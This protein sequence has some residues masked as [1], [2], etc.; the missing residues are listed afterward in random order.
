MIGYNTLQKSM[1]GVKVLTDGVSF[2]S[3]G[4]AEH[5]NIVYSEFIKS[6]T[7]HTTLSDNS[8]T[9]DDVNCVNI[10]CD[11]FD[12]S[13]IQTGTIQANYLKILNQL[14]SAI[15]L[16]VDGITQNKIIAN[17]QMTMNNILQLVNADIQ[18]TQTGR[19]YQQGTNNNYLKDTYINGYLQ[20]GSNITQSGGSAS[21]NDLT[22]DNLTMRTDKGIIQ[23]GTNVTNSFGGTSTMKTLIVTDSVTLPSNVSIPNVTTSNDMMM[24]SDAVIIQDITTVTTK[25]NILRNTKT[26]TF[27]ADGDI[28]QIKAGSTATFKNTIIQGTS[29]MQGDITQTAGTC[30]FKTINCN[31]ITLN[32]DQLITQSGTGYIT[33]SGTGQ[34]VLK[35]IN[36]LNNANIIFNG[37]GIISQALNGINILSHFRSAGYGIIGGRNNTTFTNTQ[38]IQ[39]NNGLQIQFN[40]DNSSQYSF[41]MNNRGTGGNGGIR[42]QRYVTGVY[43]DEPMVI[44]DNI[45]MNKNLSIPGGSLTCSSA[46]IGNI[47]QSELDCLDNC[48]QN[49]NTKFTSLDAQI[50]ALQTSS[51]N[52]NTALT[53]ITYNST[54]DLTTIDNNLTISA[55]KNLTVGTTN[56]INAINSINSTLSGISY[57]STQDIT[58]INNHLLLPSGNNFFLGSGYNVKTNI[59]DCLNKLSGVTYASGTDT[60]T[61]DNNLTV[62]KTLIVQGMNIKAEIDALDTSFTTGTIN[63][64]NLVTGNLTATGTTNLKTTNVIT[65]NGAT[66]TPSL[67]VRDNGNATFTRTL[68]IIPNSSGGAYNSNV[69]SNDLS[70]VGTGTSSNQTTLS[71]CTWSSTKSGFRTGPQFCELTAGTNSIF[72]DSTTGTVINGSTTFN[73]DVYNSNTLNI[74]KM[75]TDPTYSFSKTLGTSNVLVSTIT[76]QSNY[77]QRIFVNTPVSVYRNGTNNSGGNQTQHFETLSSISAYYT[78]N[79]VFVGNLTVTTNNTL[80]ATKQM[81]HINPSFIY[82]QYYT[83]ASC[84]FLPSL[85]TVSGV[86]KIYFTFT[87]S[88]TVN[89]ADNPGTINGY[90]V[91]TSV[92]S[93]QAGSANLFFISS[94]GLNYSSTSFTTSPF[95]VNY[96]NSNNNNS[97]LQINNLVSNNISNQSIIKTNTINSVNSNFDNSNISSLNVSSV[98]SN[99]NFYGNLRSKSFIAGY[100]VDGSKPYSLSP[101]FCSLS[102]ISPN[103]ADDYY[104][105]FPGYRFELYDAQDYGGTKTTLTNTSVDNLP[106]IKTVPLTNTTS[107]IKVYYRPTNNDNFVEITMPNIS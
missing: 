22:I 101:V 103:N 18:Q 39:N 105:I 74:Y 49:I 67:I 12:A 30:I 50:L 26:L 89:F 64:N 7:G 95:D 88:Y 5:Q 10:T 77:N 48:N 83:N 86:Y 42:F 53:G 100:L 44:D 81:N 45:T 24:Q 54:G 70:I 104:I 58:T 75:T 43:L 21:L 4:N 9:T 1:N 96:M 35:E 69:V 31:N 17:V 16:E 46:T 55:G 47:S 14:T 34:N 97:Q 29:Q 3:D 68:A 37:T 78:K 82:E 93:S 65:A 62:N 107:S 73:S 28:T 33:Q 41:I 106:E 15:L 8:L 11:N 59:D 13:D 51:S 61:I 98:S 2:I 32:A 94:S 102:G 60:T 27:E 99:V 80:P 40:R 38:N 6:D 23:S 56:I 84:N 91:N 52:Y 85:E 36:L 19:I 76:I 66:T 72:V 71:I 90:Y 63:T 79:D 87:F 25:K 92:S 20:V 57:D